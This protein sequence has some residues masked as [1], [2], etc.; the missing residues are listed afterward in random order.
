MAEN[1]VILAMDRDAVE[2]NLDQR[3]KAGRDTGP[4][5]EAYSEC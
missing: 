2:R 4:P 3:E 5:F 1:K